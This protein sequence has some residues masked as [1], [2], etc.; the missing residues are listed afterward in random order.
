VSLLQYNQSLWFES[1]EELQYIVGRI[2][3]RIRDNIDDEIIP[4]L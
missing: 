1:F 4:A 3:L 2:K